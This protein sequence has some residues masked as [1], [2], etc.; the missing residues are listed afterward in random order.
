MTVFEKMQT[1]TEEEMAVFVYRHRKEFGMG[2][3]KIKAFLGSVY[4]EE[5]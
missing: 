2:L 5:I 1:M 4:E 3:K